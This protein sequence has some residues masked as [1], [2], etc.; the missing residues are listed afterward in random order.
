MGDG[1]VPLGV[2]DEVEPGSLDG[3][4]EILGG[5]EDAVGQLAGFQEF[6]HVFN[7]AN[8][9]VCF[10]ERQSV[11]QHRRIAPQN[12]AENHCRKTGAAKPVKRQ[13]S[14]G[15]MKNS[16]KLLVPMCV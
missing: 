3:Y 12:R 1:V 2:S 8:R 10:L 15:E 13:L 6:E 9:E 7:V 11:G 4:L 14:L 5:L 16:I